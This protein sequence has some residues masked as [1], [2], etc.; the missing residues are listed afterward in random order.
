M[1]LQKSSSVVMSLGLVAL[2][3]FSARAEGASPNLTPKD[4]PASLIC[5]SDVKGANIFGES[6]EIRDVNTDEPY[7]VNMDA[8]TDVVKSDGTV[9]QITANNGCDNNYDIVFFAY[10]L[11]KMKR[12]EMK[13]IR[14]FM[15]FFNGN[16]I[17]GTAVLDCR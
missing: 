10:D 12:G 8:S 11:L 2:S 13:T 5:T 3:S 14:G 6:I 1:K 15:S 4:R 7:L 16:G 9:L 17:Q